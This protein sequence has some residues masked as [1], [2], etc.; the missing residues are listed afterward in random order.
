VDTSAGSILAS[1]TGEGIFEAHRRWEQAGANAAARLAFYQTIIAEKIKEL[2][3]TSGM[4]L[5]GIEMVV[6]GMASSSIGMKE[7]PY[8]EIP[9]SL[10]SPG[11]LMETNTASHTFSHSTILV[12][13]LRTSS[14]A[15]RG[16][17]TQLVGS[18]VQPGEDK[19][20]ILPG[21]HSKHVRVTHQTVVDI[22]TFM[23]GEF[24]HLLSMK[25]ILTHSVEKHDDLRLTVFREGVVRGAKSNLLHE[26]FVIRAKQLFG[27]MEKRDGYDYLKGLLLGTELKDISPGHAPITILA[28]PLIER[29]YVAALSILGVDDVTSID[30]EQATVRGHMRFLAESKQKSGA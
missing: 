22:K 1:V 13:G 7:L 14:D 30:E 4:A 25:S 18:D 16:E 10:R 11:Q 28:D 8:R 12:S 21:T 3:D 29:E 15:M 5:D 9:F 27:K 2:E 20:F 17:E 24:L 23:T 19:I 6:S 26:S